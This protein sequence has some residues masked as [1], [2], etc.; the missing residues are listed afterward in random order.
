[1]FL[2]SRDRCLHVVAAQVLLQV[3]DGQHI[4]L[5]QGQQLAQRGIRLDRLL[6][7]QAV[8]PRILLHTLGH[9]RPAHLRVLRLAQE[10]AQ[11]SRDLHRLGE[12]AGLGLGTLHGLRLALAA[13]VGLLREAGRLLLNRLQRSR[14]RRR[15]RLQARQLLLEIRDGLLERGTDVLLHGHLRG[16][17]LHGLHGLLLLNLLGLGLRRL[18]LLL[19]NGDNGNSNGNGLNGLRGLGSLLHGRTHFGGVRGSI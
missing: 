12:D 16:R 6:V 2:G 3:Q 5:I 7:H 13:A 10:R 17:D 9:R 15:R 19:N 14:R 8:V 11:L 4:T 18:R 1:M